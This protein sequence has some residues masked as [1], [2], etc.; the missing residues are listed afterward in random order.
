MPASPS[1]SSEAAT[2]GK[3]QPFGCMGAITY[4]IPAAAEGW[5]MDQLEEPGT[6]GA[7]LCLA[8]IKHFRYDGAPIR[9]WRRQGLLDLKRAVERT[10]V[11]K[12]FG[13]VSV[14]SDQILH[15]MFHVGPE[16]SS[17]H[18]LTVL[19]WFGAIKIDGRVPRSRADAPLLAR[20][21]AL[22]TTEER[23]AQTELNVGDPDEGAEQMQAALLALHAAWLL[24]VPLG[25][26]A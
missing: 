24:D 21:L 1:V 16:V 14:T 8:A 17:E 9:E 7:D 6:L 25:V 19:T 18:A 4:P 5:L 3:A 2:H 13:S 10:Y 20:I 23:R 12:L 15:A 22:A 11:K 26:D